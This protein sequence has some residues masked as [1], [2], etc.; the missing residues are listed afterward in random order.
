MSELRKPFSRHVLLK[1]M[2]A[3]PKIHA[4]PLSAHHSKPFYFIIFLSVSAQNT[5]KNLS[6]SK[7]TWKNTKK[8]VCFTVKKLH[9]KLTIQ[10][11][12]KEKKP[13]NL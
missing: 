12:R 9:K 13:T 11:T 6:G 8:S 1:Y 5:H 2:T 3:I 7:P 10:K 4:V